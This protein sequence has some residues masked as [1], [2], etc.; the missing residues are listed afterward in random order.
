MLPMTPSDSDDITS[1]RPTSTD[2]IIR[3]PAVLSRTS[4]EDHFLRSTP[5]GE[6]ENREL[7]LDL[8]VVEDAEFSAVG[9]LLGAI[10][11]FIRRGGHVRLIPPPPRATISEDRILRREIPPTEPKGLIA[12]QQRLQSL[13]QSRSRTG[14]FLDRIGF[15][16]ASMCEHLHGG[17][18]V[19][20]EGY[21]ALSDLR[22]PA[23][24]FRFPPPPRS[25]LNEMIEAV[26]Y[27]WLHVATEDDLQYATSLIDVKLESLGVPRALRS[28]VGELIQNV[29]EH[30]LY[31]GGNLSS[32]GGQHVLLGAAYL[33]TPTGKVFE[34]VVVDGGVG[35]P[36]TLHASYTS[37]HQ[38][39]GST[40]EVIAF[41]FE[42]TSTRK[43]T[44]HG[45]A[46]GLGYARQVVEGLDGQLCVRSGTGEAL[47]AS[48]GVDPVQVREGFQPG[49]VLSLTI[50]ASSGYKPGTPLGSDWDF[51]R[52]PL[53]V[54][55]L[56][57]RRGGNVER[58]GS[59]CPSVVEGALDVLL[60]MVDADSQRL[61]LESLLSTHIQE[62]GSIFIIASADGQCTHVN[63]QL[64]ALE[65]AGA[66]PQSATVLALDGLRTVDIHD[67]NGLPNPQALV[68]TVIGLA[69]D[70]VSHE[71]MAV[72][73]EALAT[74][75]LTWSLEVAS[76]W[77]EPTAMTARRAVAILG[78]MILAFSVVQS[79][80]RGS[81][82]AGRAPYVR[83]VIVTDRA[84][85]RV[86]QALANWLGATY[87]RPISIPQEPDVALLANEIEAA[88]VVLT[89]VLH[90]GGS[91]VPIVRGLLA[92]G[93]GLLATCCLVD[94]RK[95]S[96]RAMLVAGHEVPV[97]SLAVDPYLP[98]QDAIATIQLES[99]AR[100]DRVLQG[101]GV[102]LEFY[103][104]VA[105]SDGALRLGHFHTENR[106]W[107]SALITPSAIADGSTALGRLIET[108]LTEAIRTEIQAAGIPGS[109]V[110][111]EDL[112]GPTV[113]KESL[114]RRLPSTADPTI[115]DS[116]V[117]LVDW[118][119]LTGDTVVRGAIRASASGPSLVVIAIGVDR[120]W[121]GAHRLLHRSSV[122][123]ESVPR[124]QLRLGDQVEERSVRLSFV[125]AVDF[126]RDHRTEVDCPLCSTERSLMR[127]ASMPTASINSRL[128]LLRVRT[129]ADISG[130][131]TVD[132]F[133]CAMKPDEI[134]DFL[135]WRSVLHLGT[136]D[137]YI[138][139]GVVTRLLTEINPRY[140]N[141]LVAVVRSVAL[142]P[143]LLR[144]RPW[145]SPAFRRVLARSVAHFL[146]SNQAAA[147]SSDMARQFIAVL[148]I[149]SK[150]ET[151]KNAAALHRHWQSDDV[152]EELGL[153]LA[154][155]LRPNSSQ[156]LLGGVEQAVSSFET[157]FPDEVPLRIGILKAEILR[158]RATRSDDPNP[159]GRWQTARAKLQALESHLGLGSDYEKLDILSHILDE[160]RPAQRT[161]DFLDDMI[162]SAQ[163]VDNFINADYPALQALVEREIN[164]L[165]ERDLLDKPPEC[166]VWATQSRQLLDLL[167]EWRSGVEDH[168]HHLIEVRR[169]VRQVLQPLDISV[170][171]RG[172]A[173]SVLSAPSSVDAAICHARNSEVDERWDIAELG[174][175]MY[176]LFP[177]RLLQGLFEHVILNAHKHAD[178]DAEEARIRFARVE[179]DDPFLHRL[180]VTYWGT[181]RATGPPNSK[182]GLSDRQWG[183][184]LE[185]FGGGVAIQE[186][187]EDASF[188]VD[189]VFRSYGGA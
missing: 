12:N 169:L 72:A 87:V 73:D 76:K 22:G 60:C 37:T 175:E 36:H 152:R 26:P 164:P 89:P 157:A 116:A 131:E 98:S 161:E 166:E 74:D 4:I 90:G 159:V 113:L 153:A 137:R 102:D 126:P 132:A 128:R 64:E 123:V 106:A 110:A 140:A 32:S 47:V 144:R 182:G 53:D 80:I 184:A 66:I 49:T 136:E 92:A 181:M 111:Y 145:S 186:P 28:A 176:V 9:Q 19:V 31:Q 97:V 160:P 68:A 84:L 155:M 15:L 103:R 177:E 39:P 88:S 172:F 77:I 168:G 91:T 127:L 75:S 23:P 33:D 99:A 70:Y 81:D 146:M 101:E 180:R 114:R 118:G 148:R 179:T 42:A 170:E 7:R 10:E 63:S 2:A 52:N 183:G 3:R 34:T 109:N 16:E 162:L 117:V 165:V 129:S 48:S 46:R 104:A 187:P 147:I 141:E 79:L 95:D 21:E 178:P 6:V 138:A 50:P 51:E 135:I 38:Q 156:T 188:S 112:S 173:A 65:R 189:L 8:S 82:T 120:A 130:V 85:L 17:P 1:S 93:R 67:A 124:G 59:L 56:A 14:R 86:A 30:S 71:L 150:T 133:G 29:K 27:C 20:M 11:G 171:R 55:A 119:A 41:A 100:L 122:T 54:N 40:S 158:V 151:V 58:L 24:H 78:P 105:S 143:D 154:S 18:Y 43:S 174:D 163:Q 139:H 149:A 61:D 125:S 13:V 69:R 94:G 35:I 44:V 45:S 115:G 121:T 107:M 185:A 62:Q 25:D 134:E 167:I 5:K 96:S 142:N 57:L 108:R 83:D